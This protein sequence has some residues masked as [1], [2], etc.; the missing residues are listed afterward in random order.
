MPVLIDIESLV[1]AVDSNTITGIV[2]SILIINSFRSPKISLIAIR[3]S[4]SLFNTFRDGSR[5][6]VLKAFIFWSTSEG[7]VLS[8]S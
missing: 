6:I 7:V 4:K 5:Y 3:D 8:R 1:L 2:I